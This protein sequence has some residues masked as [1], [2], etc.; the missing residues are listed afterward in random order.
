[1]IVTNNDNFYVTDEALTNSPSRLEGVDE[2][3]EFHLTVYGCELI[4]EG[5]ILL[6]AW[7]SRMTKLS[8]NS[9]Q[10]GVPYCRL[11]L[12]SHLRTCAG[13]MRSSVGCEVLIQ[14]EQGRLALPSLFPIC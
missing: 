11:V 7:P 2:E 9:S 13:R 4:Q 8:F 12:I 6:K 5:S 10:S 3:T 14:G 1:M